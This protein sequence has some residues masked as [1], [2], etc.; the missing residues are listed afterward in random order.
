MRNKKTEIVEETLIKNYSKYYKLAFAYVQNDNDAMDI[1]QNASYKAI[2][3]SDSL[4][5][6]QYADTWIYRIMIN[7]AKSFIKK[8]KIIT[9]SLEDINLKTEDK[10]EDI[11]LKR[12]LEALGEPDKSI[13]VLKFFEELKIEQ[14]ADILRINQ[15]TVKSKL[16]RGLKK[17]ELFMR[18]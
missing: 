4:I 11:D 8:N 5:N 10:Y 3:K 17:L 7:E 6:I 16:Y 15:S 13:I 14:I 2:L 9:E 12:A 1:I 18:G